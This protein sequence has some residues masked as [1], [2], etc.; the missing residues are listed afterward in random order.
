MGRCRSW[1]WWSG[2]WSELPRP[3]AW[4]VADAGRP[5]G[6]E[7]DRRPGVRVDVLPLRG[8]RGLRFLAGVVQQ[9]A[10]QPHRASL[11]VAQDPDVDAVVAVD[12]GDHSGGGV[13]AVVVLR[14]SEDVD[15][16]AEFW[17]H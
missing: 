4:L 8:V 3:V 17:G 7:R 14:V 6:G 5:V 9:D 16:A 10:G 13:G 12:S 2:G 15:D 11:V 1:W